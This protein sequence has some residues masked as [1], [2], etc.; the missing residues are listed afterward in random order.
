MA[1]QLRELL[2]S[3]EFVFKHPQ[4]AARL[5]ERAGQTKVQGLAD[6]LKSLEPLRFRIW[7]P[8]LVHVAMKA[9]EARAK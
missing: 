4:L 1:T 2:R 8:S 5:I 3:R 7:K 6:V 9:R